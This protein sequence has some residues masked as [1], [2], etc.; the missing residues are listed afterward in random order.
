MNNYEYAQAIANEIT[1][2][3]VITAEKANRVVLT[4][5]RVPTNTPNISANVYTD[6]YF[7]RGFSVDE[8]LTKVKEIMSD[9]EFMSVN[10][11]M[12]WFSDF[13]QVKPRLVAR[14][15]NKKTTAEVWRSASAYG[16]DDLIIIPYINVNGGSVKVKSE[17]LSHW[18]VT[19]DEVLDIAEE[20]A[21]NDAKLQS[22]AEI[23]AEMMGASIPPCFEE[24]DP[25]MW[26]ISNTERCFGAYA[27]LALM[28]ELKKLFT[29]GFTV[30]P[31]S[32]HEVIVVNTTEN[33]DNMTGMVQDVNSTAVNTDEQLSDHAYIFAA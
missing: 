29:G 7:D 17:H 5:I 26:V 22:M 1:G 20:N 3:T 23:L 6:K 8:G 32:V 13:E 9:P 19:S 27:V 31:S 2:A 4:G 28:D 15:Y 33:A 25:Q 16:F 21:R 11:D 12:S 24:N 14:L 30:L 18:G 10:F